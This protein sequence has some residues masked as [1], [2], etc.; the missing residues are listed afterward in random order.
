MR[1]K[2]LAS[3]ALLLALPA[4]LSGCGPD[5]AG[6]AG[7]ARAGWN[8]QKDATDQM[9][10][11]KQ[12]AATRSVEVD[13]MRFDMTAWCGRGH[14]AIGISAFDGSGKPLALQFD[15]DDDGPIHDIHFRINVDGQGGESL[16]QHGDNEGANSVEVVDYNFDVG[17]ALG[18]TNSRTSS[19]TRAKSAKIE[20]PLKDGRRPIIEL[21]P[22]DS[23]YQS[24]AAMC[25]DRA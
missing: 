11:A 12:P 4:F 18:D 23:G 3:A 2:S 8:F 24:L 17:G 15:T 13:G 21:N 7:S 20:L 22:S 1:K 25:P 6:A 10:G 9:T 5:S 16:T 14:V 19:L